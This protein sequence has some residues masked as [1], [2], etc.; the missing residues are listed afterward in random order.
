MSLNSRQKRA[1]RHRAHNKNSRIPFAAYNPI[2]FIVVTLFSVVCIMVASVVSAQAALIITGLSA[3]G[4]VVFT[5]FKQRNFWQMAIDFKIRGIEDNH[6][7]F[8]DTLQTH[9]HDIAEMRQ[10]IASLKAFKNKTESTPLLNRNTSDTSSPAPLKSPHKEETVIELTRKVYDSKTQKIAEERDI[11]DTSVKNTKQPVSFGDLNNNSSFMTAS[12]AASA[13]SDAALNKHETAAE[14]AFA[15]IKTSR[16]LT[17]TSHK[18]NLEDLYK[19]DVYQRTI[20][21]LKASNDLPSKRNN[22]ATATAPQKK[23][24]PDFA[25][26][27][28]RKVQNEVATLTREDDFSDVLSDEVM[29]ELMRHAVDD[30]NIHVFIQPMMRLPQRHTRCFEMYGRIKAHPGVYIPARRFLSMARKEHFIKDLETLILI[31]CLKTLKSRPVTAQNKPMLFFM[32]ISTDSLKNVK[33]MNTL[34]SFL[35]ANR[36]MAR[37]IV[38]EMMQNDFLTIEPALLDVM[39]GLGK[40]GCHFS[41]DQVTEHDFNIEMMHAL[42][43]KFVKFD[44]DDLLRKTNSRKGMALVVDRKRKL[45]GSG[46]GFI[47][48][49]VE[50]E[51]VLKE[52]LDLNIHYG[53]GYLFGKPDLPGAYGVKSVDEHPIPPIQQTGYNSK[54]RQ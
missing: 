43:I 2:G 38:F 25:Q 15:S 17:A 51:F 13:S 16:T 22:Q 48:E 18:S 24:K 40:L 44:A 53:Q 20:P 31:E 37:Q 49:K 19:K 47:V 36:K 8:S 9:S 32:N 27:R 45:E 35:G 30:K 50:T 42:K 21:I 3:I 14:K 6:K 7:S 1:Q 4:L 39:K 46:I 12:A 29:A 52:L 33:F 34:L 41:L 11:K 5:D 10:D 28:A 23:P 54:M 26:Q